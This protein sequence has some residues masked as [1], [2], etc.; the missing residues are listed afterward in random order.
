MKIV[1]RTI[2]VRDIQ[3]TRFGA[4]ADNDISVMQVLADQ[5]AIAIENARSYE[6]SQ[7]AIKEMEEVDRLKSQFLAN[8]SHELRTPLNSIIGF[9]RVILKGIDGEINDIQQQDLNAIYHSGQHLLNLINDIL[10]LSKIEAGKMQLSFA[11]VDIREV[12]TGVMSTAIG[13]VKDKPI[14]L[15]T[16]IAENIPPVHGDATRIRQ[17]LLNFVSNAAKFTE[18]GFIRVKAYQTS[19]PDGMPEVMVEVIDTGI[20]IHEEDQ[21]KLFQ[22][23]S[24]VDDSPTRST[25]GTGLG[26]SISRSFI[27]LL[28]GR[29]GIA[30]SQEG[31][32]STF[33]F[34]VPVAS[35]FAPLQVDAPDAP[36]GDA[37]DN[38]ILSIDDEEQIANLYQR[39]LGNLNYEVIPLSRP[40]SAVQRAKE[41]KPLA[42]T[43]DM[44]MPEKDGWSVLRELKSDPDTA[45]I[46]VIICSILEEKEKGLQMG[47]AA[48]LVKPFLKEDLISVIE[49][50][51][52]NGKHHKIY[53]IDDQENDLQLI[54]NVLANDKK[55]D[56]SMFNNGKDGLEAIL[57]TPPDV[58]VLDVFLPDNYG[59][60]ILEEMS[61]NNLL[62]TVPAIILTEADLT[63]DEHKV[64]SKT[65]NFIL[66][67]NSIHKGD[68]IKIVRQ[69]IQ[70][71]TDQ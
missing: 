33:F 18:E 30:R 52:P 37:K 29:I 26:L 27:E 61:S 24:Q 49:Q 25:G 47:A 60:H 32:G 3:S 14:K 5:I 46:P 6:L 23:F 10:D 13:L 70:T 22:A 39:Y 44:M 21:N 38:I 12:V 56:I 31:E 64:I 71:R 19:S 53:V 2:G 63:A 66:S 65:E 28:N 67:K 4:F 36:Q 35:S 68:L 8:M 69:A 45:N 54:N 58:I 11:D 1:D 48:Y 41:L 62:K 7:I 51:N 59:F 42:I 43:L 40:N 57:Q 16:D 55:L 9:S 15:E 50:I 20:G 34:T 17:V